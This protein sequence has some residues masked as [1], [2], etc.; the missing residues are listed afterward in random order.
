MR[1]I[2]LVICS[3]GVLFAVPAVAGSICDGAGG[4]LVQN[5]GFET[6]DFSGWTVTPAASNSRLYVTSIAYS[7]YFGAVFGASG[8][9]Y[10]GSGPY[11]DTIAQTL[12]ATNIL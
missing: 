5:C 6:G 4:N 11:Y 3:A 2:G 1:W 12:A 8:P 9:D 7:G 10:G